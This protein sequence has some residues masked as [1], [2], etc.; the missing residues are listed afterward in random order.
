MMT[1]PTPPP[2][3]G[4]TTL[5]G[6]SSSDIVV[7]DANSGTAPFT[8]TFR[9]LLNRSASCAE[10]GYNMYFGDED[11]A[12]GDTA[13]RATWAAGTCAKSIQTLTHTYTQKGIY[14]MQI[15][16]ISSGAGGDAGSELVTVN[17]PTTSQTNT[18]LSSIANALVALQEL[19]KRLGQ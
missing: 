1:T 7:A 19:L 15:F 10:G 2:P 11:W 6:T 3:S 9:Y 4:T 13:T 8:V 16:D 12:A 5:P 14:K 17:A 18:Q